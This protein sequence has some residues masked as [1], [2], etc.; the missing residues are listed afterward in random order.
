M[1]DV[2]LQIETTIEGEKT[3]KVCVEDMYKAVNRV[4]EAYNKFIEYADEAFEK[5]NQVEVETKTNGTWEGCLVVGTGVSQPCHGDVYDEQIGN[6]IAFMKAKL[7]ANI[8]KWNFFVKLWN[9]NVK[10]SNVLN[11]EISRIETNILLD[12]HGIRKYNSDYLNGIE[13]KLGIHTTNE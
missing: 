8:K 9:Q 10:L 3:T 6:D 12:L 13:E 7:N 4:I 5:V 1:N 2:R 11:S